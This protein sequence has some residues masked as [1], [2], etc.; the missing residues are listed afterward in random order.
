MSVHGYKKLFNFLKFTLHIEVIQME[1]EFF[2]INK[3]AQFAKIALISFTSD[4]NFLYILV[5][6][7]M[8]L[9]MENLKVT[10]TK[11]MIYVK[12]GVGTK[13]FFNMLI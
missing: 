11:I 7:Q 8:P 10:R 4:L 2:V 12:R 5:V 3:E 6:Q 1:I 9:V 13:R